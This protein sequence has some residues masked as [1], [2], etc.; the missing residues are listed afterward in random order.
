MKKVF[1]L[2]D[3]NNFYAACERLF[4]PELSDK[5]IVVLSNNDGCVIARSNEVKKLGI[6]MGAPYFKN[7]AL[8]RKHNVTVFSSNYALYGDLSHRVMDVLQQLEPEVE[9][10]SIDEA[11]LSLPYHNGR[12]MCKYAAWIKEKV[13]Q[14]V[15]IPVSIGIGPTKT[16]AKIATHIAKKNSQQNGVFSLV[17]HANSDA[18]LES[19]VVADVWGI[20]R[21]YADILARRGILHALDLKNADDVWVRKHLTVNGLRTVMELRGISCLPL[22]SVPPAKKSIVSS[23]SFRRPV[24]EFSDLKEAVASYVSTAAAKLRAQGALAGAIHVFLST[25]R[26]A[27]KGPQRSVS[28]MIKLPQPSSYTPT[29]LKYASQGLARIYKSGYRYN[30]A[31]IMLV[32]LSGHLLKQANLFCPAEKESDSLMEAVDTINTRWGRNMVRF[33]AEGVAKSWRMKQAHKSPAYTTCW[34]NLPVVRAD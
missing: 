25:N 32:E 30:K 5:P 7:E 4:R 2:V 34:K 31:G 9:M 18:L 13:R 15:G 22:G 10:Y 26:F 6:S 12:E 16:L 20:G 27:A 33:A 28:T 17:N 3:C 14:C 24:C 29:L 8:L 21:Q 11:F 23:R 1:A 19:V